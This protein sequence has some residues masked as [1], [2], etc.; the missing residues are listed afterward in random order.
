MRLACVLDH[1]HPMPV[2]Y[3]AALRPETENYSR[4][5]FTGRYETVASVAASALENL[6]T[7]SATCIS[8]M[9][10]GGAMST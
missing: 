4:P 6:S 7:I 3:Q 2:R 9:M 10:N 8:L 1:R 5:I